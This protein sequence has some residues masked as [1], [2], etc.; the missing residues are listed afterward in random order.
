MLNGIANPETRRRRRSR[1]N[2]LHGFVP[3]GPGSYPGWRPSAGV[4]GQSSTAERAKCVKGNAPGSLFCR[5]GQRSLGVPA[6]WSQELSTANLEVRVTFCA[7][8]PR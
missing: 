4:L 1:L 6:T 2:R 3:A 8:F 7:G 5:W